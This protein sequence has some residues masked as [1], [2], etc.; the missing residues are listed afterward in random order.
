MILDSEHLLKLEKARCLECSLNDTEIKRISSAM[1]GL[2]ELIR[3]CG[4]DQDRNGLKETRCIYHRYDAVE[5]A[6]L[7]NL[8]SYTKLPNRL[9]TRDF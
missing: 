2:S 6:K 9:C 7:G 1:D 4:D 8:T 3:L 5:Y